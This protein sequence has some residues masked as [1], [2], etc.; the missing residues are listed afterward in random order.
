MQEQD[1]MQNKID[2][3][4]IT[5]DQNQVDVSRTDREQNQVDVSRK[6]SRVNKNG[7]RTKITTV[8]NETFPNIIRP[9]EGIRYRP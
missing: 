2:D 7:T 6:E 9:T 8:T 4:L 3:K 1:K 5:G